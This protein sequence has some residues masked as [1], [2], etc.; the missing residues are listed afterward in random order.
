MKKMR[1]MKER[2][3]S[4]VLTFVMV[5]SLFT[6]MAPVEVRAA[7]SPSADEL[8]KPITTLDVSLQVTDDGVE[9]LG[10]GSAEGNYKWV[11][12]YYPAVQEGGYEYMV[13]SF[14]SMIDNGTTMGDFKV[15]HTPE[16]DMIINDIPSNGAIER[17]KDYNILIIASIYDYPMSS[18]GSTDYYCDKIAVFDISSNGNVSNGLSG[19]GENPTP[20]ETDGKIKD[21]ASIVDYDETTNTFTVT[22][23]ESKR[24]VIT[25]IQYATGLYAGMSAS[26]F[27]E[28]Y[29]DVEDRVNNDTKNSNILE[30]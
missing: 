26:Q 5:V 19:G 10:L 11:Y 12:F 14:Q 21:L 17:Y 30:S 28:S 16:Y 9:C 3:L 6:G 20:D 22:L 23:D 1:K 18:D 27:I 2:I 4:L 24:Y 7:G 15:N 29:G 13:N 25:N 8:S